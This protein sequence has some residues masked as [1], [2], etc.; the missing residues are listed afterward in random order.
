RNPYTLTFH[1]ATGKLWVNVVG[2][3]WEQ[4]FVV[5][6]GDHAGYPME[7]VDPGSGFAT[8]SPVLA[9]P[10]GSYSINLLP[11]GR[12]GAVRSNGVVTFTTSGEHRLR[13]GGEVVITGVAQSSFNGVFSVDRVI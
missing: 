13:K 10:T 2:T 7:N 4:I 8:M 6:L 12:L 5:G 9:Y 3:S 1:P 11:A